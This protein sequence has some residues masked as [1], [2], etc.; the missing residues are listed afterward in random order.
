MDIPPEVISS[1]NGPQR[2][3]DGNTERKAQWVPLIR[4]P[5]LEHHGGW[6]PLTLC[7]TLITPLTQEWVGSQQQKLSMLTLRKAGKT[8]ESS[9][10][11]LNG[12]PFLS[13]CWGGLG[14]KE[15]HRKKL[16]TM[17]TTSSRNHRCTA[18]SFMVPCKQSA[19]QPNRQ[20]PLSY[21][22][23]THVENLRASTDLHITSCSSHDWLPLQLTICS[24]KDFRPHCR[25]LQTDFFK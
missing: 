5:H 23:K 19:F 17:E 7:N 16:L 10:C 6:Q 2:R 15:Q 4:P 14:R 22:T 24:K 9:F 18:T 3:K 11:Q 1:L 21:E 8:D 12:A 13:Q 25:N 20:K